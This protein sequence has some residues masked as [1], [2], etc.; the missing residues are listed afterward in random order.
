MGGAYFLFFRIRKWVRGI[1]L[2]VF[3]SGMGEK[4]LHSRTKLCKSLHL[5]LA[6]G[7]SL[8]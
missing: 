4:F 8:R 5:T 6:M 2:L 7:F 3:L 1:A